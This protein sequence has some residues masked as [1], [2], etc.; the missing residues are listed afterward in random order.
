MHRLARYCDVFD[1]IF[2]FRL[3]P[4][5]LFRRWRRCR[6]SR[7]TRISSDN[8]PHFIWQRKKVRI[9]WRNG[10]FFLSSLCYILSLSCWM[11]P[12]VHR[13]SL[14][15][16]EYITK[17]T[18]R[19]CTIHH[20]THHRN[21]LHMDQVLKKIHFCWII[22]Q[23]FSI[24]TFIP[25]SSI[26]WI[27]HLYTKPTVQHPLFLCGKISIFWI[28]RLSFRFVSFGIG[29]GVQKKK[30]LKGKE[31]KCSSMVFSTISFV[32][33]VENQNFKYWCCTTCWDK[34]RINENSHSYQN[35]SREKNDTQK[36]KKK[37][38]QTTTML[39]QSYLFWMKSFLRR[40]D[41]YNVP[42]L[43]Y[44]WNWWMQQWQSAPN[45]NFSNAS[46]Y[47]FHQKILYFP[48]F[49]SSFGL[50]CQNMNTNLI[51]IVIR[52][53]ELCAWVSFIYLWQKATGYHELCTY[54]PVLVLTKHQ[55][56]CVC[57]TCW[58][59]LP[60]HGTD[61]QWIIMLMSKDGFFLLSNRRDHGQLWKKFTTQIEKEKKKKWK[62][63]RFL[64][65]L[66]RLT[67]NVG[68]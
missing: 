65:Y 8:A 61:I 56:H 1:F 50:S 14:P 31:K 7:H 42:I 26:L 49:I 57:V 36:E 51:I 43:I 68:R 28:I 38:N 58:F 46:F 44:H 64:S 53:V 39:H 3:V 34:K 47:T 4:Y 60:G 12:L 5:Y 29:L 19:T 15:F 25:T 2:F 9:D 59:I 17:E 10:I 52:C 66:A 55:K 54:V 67:G 27:H 21:E 24:I 33:L 63:I 30:K 18:L 32:G 37:K 16:L 6:R 41:V 35:A 45:M 48:P 13:V 20:R 23:L 22:T 40:Y 62:C 11:H